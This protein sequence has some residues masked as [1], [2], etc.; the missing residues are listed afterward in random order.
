MGPRRGRSPRP[1]NQTGRAGAGA[2]GALLR[3][4]GVGPGI[5]LMPHTHN[6]DALPS[7]FIVGGLVF[8]SLM[9]PYLHEFGE[10]PSPRYHNDDDQNPGVTEIYL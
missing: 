10:V 9:Q 7:Y 8:V 2:L 3:A 6:F 1:E 5:P 4:G